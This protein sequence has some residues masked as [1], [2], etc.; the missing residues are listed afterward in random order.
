MLKEPLFIGRWRAALNLSGAAAVFWTLAM[1]AA[2]QPSAPAAV[3]S[4]TSETHAERG[5]LDAINDYRRTQGRAAWAAEPAL[6]A[7]A[8]AHSQA[9][10]QRGRFSHDGFPHRAESTGSALCVEN[11]LQGTVTP[12]RAIRLWTASGEH[13]DNLLEPGA[14][15][16]GI[17]IAGRFVTLLAC[18]TPPDNPVSA[19]AAP[20]HGGTR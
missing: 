11:L 18:A 15:F 3:S 8:R 12:A 20:L 16:A 13:R 6:A 5:L 7:V 1:P 10:L 19:D 4:T 9:M 17:G 14:R 2:S